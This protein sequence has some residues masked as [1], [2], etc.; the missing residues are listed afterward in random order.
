MHVTILGRRWRLKRPRI[1]GD[2]VGWCDDPSTGRDIL[3][4]RRLSGLAELDTAI[5]EILH[6]AAPW[7]RESFVRSAAT[8]IA[9]SLWELGYRRV[10][11]GDKDGQPRLAWH[12]RRGLYAVA[13][14][15]K[16]DFL[17]QAARDSAHTLWRLGYRKHGT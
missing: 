5:H 14:W 2:Y 7:L 9:R 4:D 12:L 6:A 15:A 17:T 8:Q 16:P 1:R 3:I 11:E 13:P 10:G